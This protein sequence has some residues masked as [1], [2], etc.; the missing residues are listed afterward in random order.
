LCRRR[1]LEEACESW[2][3]DDEIAGRYFQ[4]P[5]RDR[6]IVANAHFADHAHAAIPVDGEFSIMG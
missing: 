6:S 4:N 2:G 5:V 1:Q 3:N